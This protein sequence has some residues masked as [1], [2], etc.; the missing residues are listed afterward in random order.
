MI[1]PEYVWK[2]LK[3]VSTLQEQNK[4][5]S[6]LIFLTVMIGAENPQGNNGR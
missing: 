3:W 6:F 4:K 5:V 2:L 1:E